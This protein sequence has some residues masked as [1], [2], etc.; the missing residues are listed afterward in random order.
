MKS[1]ENHRSAVSAVL[2]EPVYWKQLQRTPYH[3][4]LRVTESDPR[5]LT[6]I[7]SYVSNKA[8]FCDNWHSSV[9]T[10]HDDTQQLHRHTHRR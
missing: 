4:R 7:P 1:F 10:G 8:T 3:K 9:E 6:I 2:C 5:P